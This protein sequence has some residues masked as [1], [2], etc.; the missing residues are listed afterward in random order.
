MISGMG[1]QFVSTA[2]KMKMIV[3]A[4]KLHV[5]TRLDMSA[6]QVAVIVQKWQNGSTGKVTGY[7][8]G[9]MDSLAGFTFNLSEPKPCILS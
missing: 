7:G 3:T 2:Q 5:V 6:H 4:M 1:I 8:E 9:L